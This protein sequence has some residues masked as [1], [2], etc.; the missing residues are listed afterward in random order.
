M[1]SVLI[2]T[3]NG[4]RTLPA[5]L[6]RL[7]ALRPAPVPHRIAIVDNASTDATP[8]ILRAELARNGP[9]RLPLALLFEPVPGKNR[10]LNRALDDDALRV[11][12]GDLVVFT[13]DDTLPEPDWLQR[14]WAASEAHPECTM[15]GGTIR[16]H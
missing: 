4:A 15:F 9:E 13:D 12:A 11:A 7:R 10:A 6:E 14:H 16:P 2:A 3:R 8:A 1:I 5:A